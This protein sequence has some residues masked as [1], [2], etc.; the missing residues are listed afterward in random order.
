[1]T[2][3]LGASLPEITVS[4]FESTPMITIGLCDY[5]HSRCCCDNLSPSTLAR[6]T[7]AGLIPLIT[8]SSNVL[9]MLCNSFFHSPA[10]CALANCVGLDKGV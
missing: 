2:G 8:P 4:G 5:E 10:L 1:M 9:W 6:A 3:L 7:P